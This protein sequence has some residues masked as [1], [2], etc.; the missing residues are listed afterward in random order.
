MKNKQKLEILPSKLSW[1]WSAIMTEK[2]LKDKDK[3]KKK[4][5]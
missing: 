3:Q 2:L 5:T 1:S 4:K